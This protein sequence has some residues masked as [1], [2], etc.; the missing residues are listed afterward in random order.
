MKR[1]TKTQ[2]HSMSPKDLAT[3]IA[4]TEKRVEQLRVDRFT[5][6]QKNVREVRELRQKIAVLKTMAHM[7]V[8]EAPVKE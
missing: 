8:N 2:I 5:K 7:Q 4:E 1:N 3:Q 6:Q